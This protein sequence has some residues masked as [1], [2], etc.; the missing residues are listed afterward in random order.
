MRLPLLWGLLLGVLVAAPPATAQVDP[1]G[2]LV[3]DLPI[4]GPP[5]IAIEPAATP[6]QVP[7]RFT[8][9]SA[10]SASAAAVGGAAIAWTLGA[11]DAGI[12]LR[13]EPTPIPVEPGTTDY[14][15]VAEI[16]FTAKPGTRGMVPL[17]CEL[18]GT[19]AGAQDSIP[20]ATDTKPFAPVVDFVGGIEVQVVDDRKESGPQKQIPYEIEVTNIGNA[21]TQVTFELADEPSGKWQSI[22]P[23]VVVLEPGTTLTAIFTVATP[24]GNGYNSD[25][26]HYAIRLLPAAAD[27]P[28]LTADPIEVELRASAQGWYVPGPSPLMLL[29]GLALAALAVRRLRAD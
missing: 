24:F 6:W 23:E 29:A 19:V 1:V 15:G 3:L 14:R 22:L 7:W 28:T 10:A 8:F 26:G 20:P 5:R 2:T 27:D 21:R 18:T 17:P 12:G 9:S 25:R 16:G 4:E 13:A 11:C